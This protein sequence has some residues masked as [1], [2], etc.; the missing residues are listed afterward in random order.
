MSEFVLAGDLGGTNLRIAAVDSGGRLLFR[1]EADTPRHTDESRIVETAVTLA[2]QCR[3]KLDAEPLA[4]G[5]AIPA[6]MAADE[7]R[8][9]SS[10]NLPELGGRELGRSLE[11]KLDLDVIL[12]NDATAAAIG[13]HWL[14]ASRDYGSSICVT[15]GTG[16]GG[17]VIIDGKPLRGPDG[18]AGEVGH[19]C[20]EPLGP[21]CG[22]GS[23]GCLEQFSSAS[24]IVRIAN[25]LIATYPDTKLAGAGDFNALDVF[26]LG[27]EGDP[28][29]VEVFRTA[30]GYLGIALAG[31]IN[32]LNPEAIVIG[33]GAAEGWD[34]FIDATKAEIRKRAFREPAE[35]ARIVRATLGSDA[36]IVGAAFLAFKKAACSGKPKV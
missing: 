30:G 32:V 26:Q 4:F 15:L 34:L 6:I 22:C 10:P 21:P 2:T 9:F 33:G 7:E 36:G 29:C 8:I 23:N 28:L 17:G 13:E 1:V 5:F 31:L 20:V 25:E 24:A 35:R 27:M 12:E 3:E 14:G 16:V 18:T 11:E 19:I